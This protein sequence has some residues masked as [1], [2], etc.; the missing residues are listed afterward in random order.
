M[1]VWQGVRINKSNE[2]AWGNVTILHGPVKAFFFFLQVLNAF[3]SHHLKWW[4]EVI[5][6]K[7]KRI[8]SPRKSRKSRNAKGLVLNNRSRWLISVSTL[9]PS[10]TL[11]QPHCPAVQCLCSSCH[12]KWKDNSYCYVA[13]VYCDWFIAS[14]LGR[15]TSWSYMFPAICNTRMQLS[16]SWR[17]WILDPTCC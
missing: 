17:R 12:R 1:Y 14:R 4:G 13:A 11:T 8:K 15:N 9:K 2:K 10:C 5:K 3:L 7:I 16:R 6:T